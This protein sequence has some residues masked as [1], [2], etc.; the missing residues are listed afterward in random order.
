MKIDFRSDTVTRPS[1]EMRAAMAEA[2]VG[3]DVYG[4]DPTVNKLE[5][6]VATLLGKSA[7]LF[8]S[9]GTQ[10]NIVAVLTHCQRGEELIVGDKYHIYRYEAG[11][12]SAL[13][14]VIMEPISTDRRGRMKIEN[15]HNAAKPDDIHYAITK[16]LCLENTVNGHVHEPNSLEK[17]VNV[18]R[19]YGLSVHLDGA[20]L[21]N[22]AIK[23]GVSPSDLSMSMDTV[24]LCLSKGLGAPAGSVLVGPKDFIRRARRIRKMLG[25]GL[26]QSGIIAAA[27]LYA[28]DNNVDRLSE[29]H[30][31]ARYL[32]D[33]LNKIPEIKVNPSDVE[34]NMVFM[35]VPEGSANALREKL[36]SQKILI[37]D[38]DKII[39]LVTHLEV[40]SNACDICVS[41]IS[42]FY[43]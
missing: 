17:V 12:A 33:A 22:A 31:T 42:N 41:A 16:L 10:S 35:E 20:R 26:R 43:G 27:G 1:H 37:G 4:E 29:D 40:D 21:L 2:E 23:L 32:V 28:L 18:A 19:T 8:V 24:S 9:S 39:R 7:G 6:R 11:G 25:G 5:S 13:G 3:D 15:V 36:A 34:T 30:A 14:G 38:G